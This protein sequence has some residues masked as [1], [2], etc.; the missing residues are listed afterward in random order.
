MNPTSNP[1][2]LIASETTAFAIFLFYA[3]IVTQLYRDVDPGF[4][5]DPMSWRLLLSAVIS[6]GVS[7]DS[8]RPLIDP[9]GFFFAT[10]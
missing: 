6:G 3:V 7:K 9:L 8:L 5:L 4:L 10:T 1:R 2:A